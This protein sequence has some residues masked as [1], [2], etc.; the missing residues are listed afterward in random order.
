M[1][2]VSGSGY[3]GPSN[4]EVLLAL[5]PRYDSYTV[6]YIYDGFSWDHC[7]EDFDGLLT[8]LKDSHK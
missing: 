8:S 4:R 2:D 1:W 6:P 7:S 5:D 3:F